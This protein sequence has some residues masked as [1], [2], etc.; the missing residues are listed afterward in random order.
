M[1]I[2]WRR[3]VNFSKKLRILYI[4]MGK[5]YDTHRSLFG[6]KEI[7]ETGTKYTKY[8]VSGTEVLE[9]WLKIDGV[10][11]DNT[12]NAR[13]EMQQQVMRRRK[14]YIERKKLSEAFLNITDHSTEADQVFKKFILGGKR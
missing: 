11:T 9:Q 4:T 3:I 7:D 8:N 12:E 13:K 6:A 2:C 14:E 5:F 10:W 1:N